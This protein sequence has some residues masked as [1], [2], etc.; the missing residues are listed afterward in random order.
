MAEK[1]ILSISG[2]KVSF[3]AEKEQLN[4]QY[5]KLE[6]KLALVDKSLST[7][8]GAELKKQ[9]NALDVLEKKMLR[10]FKKKNETAITQIEKLKQQLFP[11]DELQERHDNFIPFYLKQGKGFIDDLKKNLNPF[12]CRFAILAEQE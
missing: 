6:E 2:D 12:D 11:N 4:K 5:K 10:S 8:A 3:N 9:L 1:Y 7:S